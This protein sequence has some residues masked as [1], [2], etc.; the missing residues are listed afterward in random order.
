MRAHPAGVAVLLLCLGG[1]MLW[2]C[3]LVRTTT[4]AT[5]DEVIYAR[6]ALA[7]FTHGT[8]A[9]FEQLG[10]APLPVL[11]GYLPLAA[12]GVRL[13]V[14]PEA[15]PELVEAARAAHALLI[16]VPLV[17]CVALWLVRRRGLAAGAVGGALAAFSPTLI[18]HTSLATTDACLA[19]FS[20]VALA[21]MV[22]HSRRPSR[23]TLLG[24]GLAMGLGFA[25]KH[26]AVFLVPV[27]LAELVLVERRGRPIASAVAAAAL[28]TAV[29][30]LVAFAVSAAF[31]GFSL[32]APIQ[33]VLFQM[34]HGRHGHETYLM[35]R[36]AM[37]TWWYYF[38]LAFVFKSTPV[39]LILGGVAAAAGVAALRL[40]QPQ[41][42]PAPRL[43]ALAGLVYAALTVLSP[44]GIGQ[45]YLLVLYPLVILL[46]VDWG[47]AL[48]GGS[49]GLRWATAGAALAVLIQAASAVAVSPQYLAYFSPLVGG[50]AE[51][52]RYLVDSNLDW[53]QDL[54]ALRAR[55]ADLGGGCVALAYFGTASPR[56][57][58]V[59]DVAWDEEPSAQGERC[60]WLAVSATFL[61]GL[62]LPGDPF[63]TLRALSPA[64]RAGYSIFLF[65]LKDPAVQNAL[66]E[67]QRTAR[68]AQGTGVG[69]RRAP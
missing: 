37:H 17:W 67:A 1:V 60:D 44:L 46:A 41:A 4:S 55:L 16:G 5:W 68:S 58:G 63:A 40:R 18:A 36:R 8:F 25:S 56:A 69:G 26:S 21:A 2:Q 59:E 57:Y 61:Q 14:A 54:P 9:I 35:G 32:S 45:R 20:L 12:S 51:G 10:T 33:G 39:E 66:A 13:P 50:P 23:W 65:S 15:I 38:P 42:D 43:W 7:V 30:T 22:R 48:A 28:Q 62:Y 31:H 27:L 53:G 11:L 29:A 52:H 19:L 3:G 49:R 34:E 6:L 47:A 64:A 24:V